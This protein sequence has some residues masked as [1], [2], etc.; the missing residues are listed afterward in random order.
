MA[1]DGVEEDV[2]DDFGEQGASSFEFGFW[3]SS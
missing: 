3:G 1:I 2:L